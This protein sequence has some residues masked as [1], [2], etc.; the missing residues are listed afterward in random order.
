MS[1]TKNITGLD[2]V[3]AHQRKGDFAAAEKECR[4]LLD[5]E[6]ENA[7]AM[8]LLGCL[9]LQTGRAKPAVEQI[10]RAIAVAEKAN[11][12]PAPAWQ[13][14]LGG[15]RK[16]AGDTDGALAAFETALA[17]DPNFVDARYWRA[18]ILWALGRIDE[19]V[20]DLR[21]V[22]NQAPNHQQ[23]ASNLGAAL[24]QKGD[25]PGAVNV[26]RRAVELNPDHPGALFNLGLA[27]KD[28]DNF[29]AAL[30]PLR[31]SLQLAPDN[32]NG[33]IL[34]VSTLIAAARI[35]EAEGF[36]ETGLSRWP[37]NNALMS[38]GGAARLAVG[39]GEG[40]RE[41]LRKVLDLDPGC[42]PA[43]LYF[44][45]A[46]GDMDDES[47]IAQVETA[48]AQKG[49]PPHESSALHFV[50]GRRYVKSGKYEE[51][52]AHYEQGN[53]RKREA[54]ALL[55]RSYDPAREERVVNELMSGFGADAFAKE[56]GSDS[57]L[58]VFIIGMPRS[59]TSL[60]EQIL[61]SHP[62][63]GGGGELQ[64]LNNAAARLRQEAGYPLQPVS[65]ANLREIA[66]AYLER[67][68]ETDG[69]AVRITDKMPTNF[70]ILGLAA[71]L[72]PNSRIIHVRRHPMDIGLSSYFQN[73]YGTG[74]VFIYSFDWFAHYYDEYRR[75]ME[76]WRTVLPVNML[77][78][79]YEALVADQE[80]ESRR[81][82]EFLGLEWDEACLE[83]H[84][85]E[86]PVVTAS[87]TQV[88]R[89]MYN[90]SVGAWKRYEKQLQPLA[91]ALAS[92]AAAVGDVRKEPST[93]M[94]EKS[95][96]IVGERPAFADIIHPVTP[97][98]F[99]SEYYG[100]KPLHIQGG[101]EKFS[102]V[103]S[104][105]ILTGILN[106]TAVWSSASLQL[107]LDKDELAPARYSRPG[108]NRD[109]HE[110]MQPDSEKVMALLKSGASLVANDIDSLTPAL[111][112]FAAALEKA[113]SGK[114]Q[115][116][117]YCSWREWQ[118]FGSHFDTHDVF[119]MHVAGEKLWNL[120]ETRADTPVAHP[121]F[122]SYGQ[123]WHDKNRGEVAQQVVMRPGDLLYLPRG[124]YHDALATSNGTI[125][126]AFGLT[127]VIGLDVLSMLSTM[128]VADPA[129]RANMPRPEDGE[130]ATA[131]WLEAL[132]GKLAEYSKNNEA[133][134]AMRA[135]Q[136]D[137]RYTRG[138]FA[139]PVQAPGRRFAV[140][141][142]D[143]KVEERDGAWVLTGTKG[144]APIPA[145]MDRQVAWVVGRRGFTDGDFAEAFPETAD[146]TR[147]QVLKDL[148]NMNVVADE[149]GK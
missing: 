5:N 55:G 119:A 11:R 47:R 52:F 60:V 139:L 62:E 106:M 1:R 76:H 114:A 109:G 26:L 67:L 131:A 44:A 148:A 63:V 140:R 91:R 128:A 138:G 75:L 118:A 22:L 123:E 141:V 86:R 39:D 70:R 21:A 83:F 37:D 3:L 2:A 28:S 93:A 16:S 12:K 134:A 38:Y 94:P 32:L 35:E 132:G 27:L 23:A 95:N 125:H 34:L 56:G 121:E 82:V 79:D 129:F 10:D 61:A 85:T 133:L 147:E 90:S 40:A 105:D 31:R 49:L 15:A 144:S 113:V 50:A 59:G 96:L 101:A 72:F 46:D 73:F 69:D 99:F 80:S 143:L 9:L 102:N 92:P 142:R 84:K 111:S 145:G 120:Y 88:R 135:F 146:E 58:P 136:R 126:I 24:H 103:M 110:I 112:G 6:P 124:L 45:E 122:K 81:L 57:E 18:E 25:I 127:H 54:L 108:K 51:G 64:H 66:K 65:G 17:A 13:V 107:V 116:N 19:A 98:V 8:Y 33:C 48:L 4:A 41:I 115:A 29:E 117:L 42:V 77:E 100:K 36:I 53:A 7:D 74:N 104:W 14:A 97:D 89:P 20:E 137:F 130:A 43:H 87:Q 68:K 78:L 149:T 71:R 30:A